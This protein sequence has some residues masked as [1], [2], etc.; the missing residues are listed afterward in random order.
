MIFENKKDY[1]L[2]C[3]KVYKNAI[4]SFKKR[5]PE[6][7]IKIVTLQDFYDSFSY[8]ISDRAVKELLQVSKNSFLEIL[9]EINIFRFLNQDCH[10][11][12]VNENVLSD[13]D[14]IK[15]NKLLEYDK[16]LDKKKEMYSI[17]F[18]EL[19][20][21][22]DLQTFCNIY[23]IKGSFVTFTDIGF[24]KKNKSY[25]LHEFS[26]YLEEVLFC[27]NKVNELLYKGI[28][29]NTIKVYL[30]DENYY[31]YFEA[32][33]SVCNF[34]F[35]YSKKTPLIYESYN[36][37]DVKEIQNTRSFDCLKDSKTD[38]AKLYSSFLLDNT[39]TFDYK[40]NAL[41]E[42]LNNYKTSKTFNSS[43]IEIINTLDFSSEN[44]ILVL[45]LA[46]KVMPK[47]YLDTKVFSDEVFSSLKCNTSID[48]TAESNRIYE[49][50]F[51]FINIEHVSFSIRSVS[52][53][54]NISSLAKKF[55]MKIDLENLFTYFYSKE[56]ALIHL[57]LQNDLYF[58]F[59]KESKQLDFLRN[60]FKEYKRVYYEP[61]F[62]AFNIGTERLQDKYSFSSLH[63][64]VGCH[65]SYF[66][67]YILNINDEN[68]FSTYLGLFFHAL[69][70]HVYDDTFNYEI[71]FS[72]GIKNFIEEQ[73][74][75]IID[76]NRFK[77]LAYAS[78]ENFKKTIDFIIKKNDLI[79][80]KSNLSEYKNEYVLSDGSIVRGSVDSVIYINDY[81][82]LI[83]YKTGKYSN[84]KNVEDFREGNSLQFPIYYLL[85]KNFKGKIGGC[86]Y[87][88][89]LPQNANDLK[90]YMYD[91][92]F[93]SDESFYNFNKENFDENGNASFVKGVKLNSNGNINK[94]FSNKMLI[95]KTIKEETDEIVTNFIQDIK[96]G[97]FEIKPKN[98]ACQYCI[99]ADV[100]YSK[101]ENLNEEESEDETD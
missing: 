24:E 66:C 54:F 51:N 29:A 78:K 57:N 62:K 19:E 7:R 10:D 52:S 33:S 76:A 55:S 23:Q 61:S 21:N 39:Q 28:D 71:D 67:K 15:K 96:A 63:S 9:S 17:L 83:D 69:L 44:H 91:G 56:E 30:E 93:F 65:F 99:F 60:N 100:C 32:L 40:F 84:L 2:I 13:F 34:K 89:L 81:Y 64:Y 72:K 97:K 16:F 27:I 22:K 43:G 79:Q 58:R 94:N 49:N 82:Y 75:D 90:P 74:L 53:S 68:T 5:N 20:N 59:K 47:Q 36:K 11:E 6:L 35:C 18:F 70:E 48:L 98:N 8:A 46:D 25:I 101:N 85:T 12:R 1:L 26:S 88:H 73:K 77:I 50:F 42:M 95:S 41:I 86:L 14:Y 80:I 37:K 3:D 31:T 38:L 87:Q 92:I 45:G 4:L